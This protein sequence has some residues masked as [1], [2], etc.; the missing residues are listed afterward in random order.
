MLAEQAFDVSASDGIGGAAMARR[1]LAPEV[2][3]CRWESR[4]LRPANCRCNRVALFKVKRLVVV[5]LLEAVKTTLEHL[6][7]RRLSLEHEG[8]AVPPDL[9]RTYSEVRRLRDF[10]LRCISVREEEIELDMADADQRLLV[11]C[12]R[13][14]VEVTEV[15]LASLE[16][17][18]TDEVTLLR[19]KREIVAEWALELATE[20]LIELP[21]HSLSLA[22]TQSSRA[23]F[24]RLQQKVKAE[25]EQAKPPEQTT[26]PENA[27]VPNANS[28]AEATGVAVSPVG[29]QVGD[30]GT[31]PPPQ[32][33]A[34]S[35]VDCN[36][37]QDPRL[38]SVITQ[39]L[40]SYACCLETGDYRMAE[41]LLACLM[42]SALLDHVLPRRTQLGLSGPPETWNLKPL[43]IRVMGQG[44]NSRDRTLVG[45][46]F[47]ARTLLR[48]A[49]QMVTPVPVT[50]DSFESLRDLV[51]R[52]MADL[53]YTEDS[54]ATVHASRD[55]R[56]K[57]PAAQ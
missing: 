16:S 28:G 54:C 55:A 50:L 51:Q 17:V 29:H 13:R 4:E 11:A 26:A 10:L 41:V 34:T 18:A 27:Q 56:A 21:L 14:F 36:R 40:A 24:A 15:S 57:D 22:Q 19:K 46:L 20:P 44:Y 30:V 5:C 1:A 25:R 42:E 48:P 45:N 33:A 32:N 3:C 7:T 6:G 9:T 39:D 8:S 12:C 23:L 52:V 37:V 2:G 47:A 31:P 53:R 49:E 35:L 43:L 38:R